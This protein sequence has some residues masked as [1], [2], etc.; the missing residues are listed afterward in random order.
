MEEDNIAPPR[1]SYVR[2]KQPV[3]QPEGEDNEIAAAVADV[4]R[5]L[6]AKYGDDEEPE[7]DDGGEDESSNSEPPQYEEPAPMPAKIT[8]AE[9]IARILQLD[10]TIKDPTIERKLPSQYR[11]MRL[12][13]LKEI[14]SERMEAGAR[15]LKGHME[16]ERAKGTPEAEV[17]IRAAHQ[18]AKPETFLFNINLMLMSGA[19]ALSIKLEPRIKTSLYGITDDMIQDRENLENL[20]GAIY[21]ENKEWMAIF[22]SPTNQYLFTML[23]M[24]G[25]RLVVNRKKNVE[26][27]QTEEK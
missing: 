15:V 24:M 23:G 16:E 9:L 14:L 26:P 27:P 13:E 5:D 18:M 20:L 12:D 6:L 21:E 11:R 25:R 4:E 1:T 19:E 17:P 3:I 7:F 8:K 10:T 2:V 22:T